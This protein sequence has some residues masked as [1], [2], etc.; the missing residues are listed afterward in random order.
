[1]EYRLSI[2]YQAS[3]IL[4]QN[5]DAPSQEALPVQARNLYVLP[6]QEPVITQVIPQTGAGQPILPSSTLLIQ[7]TNL[8]NDVVSVQLGNL[9]VTPAKVTNTTITLPV[10]ST[11]AAGVLGVQVTQ[12]LELG[13]PPELHP[14]FESNIAAIVLHPVIVPT[15]ANSTAIDLTIT[16]AVQ[17]G[18]RVTLLLNQVTLPA[19]PAQPAAYSFT[20]PPATATS[21]SLTFTITGVQTGTQYF[22]RVAIDGAESLL[23]FD[24]TSLSFG[25][26]VTIA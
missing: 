16:P 4:I 20:L 17:A 1:V 8:S 15:S 13:T 6:F 25:P 23:D 3:V 18:Q 19:P 21:L 5:D 12:Q 9:V 7:G 22:I 24:P 11:A 2:A 14:G 10:P 26:T